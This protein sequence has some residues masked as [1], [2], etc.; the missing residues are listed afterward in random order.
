M[1]VTVIVWLVAP[2]GSDVGLID[3]TVAGVF[4]V[5]ALVAVTAGEKSGLVTVTSRTPVQPRRRSSR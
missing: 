2:C 1:P 5:K 3:V 4:T